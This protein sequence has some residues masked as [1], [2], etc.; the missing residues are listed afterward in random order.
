M[1]VWCRF[2]QQ[3]KAAPVHLGRRAATTAPGRAPQWRHAEHLVASSAVCSTALLAARSSRKQR[4]SKHGRRCAVAVRAA[5]DEL[6]KARAA[7]EAAELELEAAKLRQELQ[8][9]EQETATKRRKARA[10]RVLS[11]GGVSVDPAELL[12]QLKNE[13]YNFNAEDMGE[14]MKLTSRS[15]SPE[16]SLGFEELSS[17]LFEKE[18]S[19][20]QERKRVAEM[21]EIRQQRLKA[22][23]KRKRE[24]IDPD[25]S[26]QTGQTTADGE[27]DTQTKILSALAYLLPL[28]EALQFAV[29]LFNMAPALAL[30]FAPAILVNYLITTIP[31]GGLICVLIFTTVAQNRDLP[32]SLRF[33]LEQAV[34]MD[35]ALLFPS[36]FYAGASLSGYSAAS[37][38]ISVFTFVLVFIAVTW[39]VIKILTRGEIPDDIPI[40]SKAAKNF[41]DGGTFFD[42]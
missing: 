13:G 10:E 40:I 3:A 23:A 9:M 8:E 11:G 6:E 20:L 14:L 36:F 30:L 41:I 16:A 15:K 2:S 31:L 34:L 29:P 24:A 7:K 28:A 18:L 22:E 21:E 37:L 17:E 27:D 38:G 19:A 1:E 4:H 26:V 5:D 35:I 32:R 12:T 25:A 42:R 39:C 33:N